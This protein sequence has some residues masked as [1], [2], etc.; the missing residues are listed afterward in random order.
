[1]SIMQELHVHDQI[2]DFTLKL[3]DRKRNKK[4]IESCALQKS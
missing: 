1:M 4:S 3:E 2:D